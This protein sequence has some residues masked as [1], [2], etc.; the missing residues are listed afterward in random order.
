MKKTGIL[1][2]IPGFGQ[3]HITTML[4]DYTGTLSRQGRL[5]DGVKDGLR[6]LAELLEIHVITA[7]TYGF[8]AEELKGVPVEFFLLTGGCHDAKKREY[9]AKLGLKNCI[10]F[11]NG[12]NDR[13]LL[14]AAKEAG[15]I[16]ISVDNGEGCATDAILNSHLFIVGAVNALGL[17]LEP[18]GL[19]ATLRS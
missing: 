11:G 14:A 16:A 10:V 3:R 6:V 15:G 2:D 5:V 7:D 17:L 19:K 4:T 9:G 12:N 1:V 13:L 18:L 8:A